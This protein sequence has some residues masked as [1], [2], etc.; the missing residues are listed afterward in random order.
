MKLI[1]RTLEQARRLRGGEGNAL[2]FSFFS[3]DLFPAPPLGFF[4]EEEVAFFGRKKR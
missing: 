2:R 3:P 1:S 4:W